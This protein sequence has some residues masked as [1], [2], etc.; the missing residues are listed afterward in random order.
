MPP[1]VPG[2]CVGRDTE[3]DFYLFEILNLPINFYVTKCPPDAKDLLAAAFLSVVIFTTFKS[4]F[5]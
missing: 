4:N 3:H 1:N 2:L 5:H